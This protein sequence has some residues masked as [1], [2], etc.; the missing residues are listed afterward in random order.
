MVSSTIYVRSKF[1]YNTYKEERTQRSLDITL[2]RAE[3]EKAL[4]ASGKERYGY[5]FRNTGRSKPAWIVG[6]APFKWGSIV[7]G[8][9]GGEVASGAHVGILKY[10]LNTIPSRKV[11]TNKHH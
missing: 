1:M 2:Y 7:P 5:L 9:G 10:N 6:L 3:N 8:G 11:A 4:E